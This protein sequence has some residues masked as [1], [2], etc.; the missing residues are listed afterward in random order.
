MAP[1]LHAR[2]VEANGPAAACDVDLAIDACGRGRDVADD[3]SE[4]ELEIVDVIEGDIAG[5]SRGRDQ[6]G[7]SV[8]DGETG[9]RQGVERDVAAR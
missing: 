6:E 9:K 7:A 2:A 5:A 8:I 1:A 4:V 3:A